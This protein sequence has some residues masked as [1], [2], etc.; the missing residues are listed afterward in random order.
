MIIIFGEGTDHN[1]HVHPT[2]FHVRQNVRRASDP[3]FDAHTAVGGESSQM[4]SWACV[5]VIFAQGHKTC[6]NRAVHGMPSSSQV[7][8]TKSTSRLSTLGLRRWECLV[9]E[10]KRSGIHAWNH[11]NLYAIF[12]DTVN[13]KH[14]TNSVATSLG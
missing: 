4:T 3:Y 11:L 12:S 6:I 14:R 5:D 2:S 13:R 10:E 1:Q 8:G 9:R 7:N